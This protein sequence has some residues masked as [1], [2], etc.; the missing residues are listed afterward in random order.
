MTTRNFFRWAL[1]VILISL[2]TAS[3]AAEPAS[4]GKAA[5]KSDAKSA[6]KSPEQ[7]FKELDKNGDGK[8]KADEISADQ[9]A[10]FDHLVRNADKDKNGE[11]TLAEFLEGLK[12]EERRPAD[13]GGPPRGDAP[14]MPEPGRLFQQFDR[15]NDG[16][17]SLDEMPGPARERFKPAFDRLGKTELNRE[18][19]RRI[20]AQVRP[21]GVPMP[22]GG[23]NSAFFRKLD[24]NGDGKISKDELQNAAKIF[25]ELDVDKSGYLEPRELFGPP[26]GGPDGRPGDRPNQPKDGKTA[27]N[28][29]PSRDAAGTLDSNTAGNKPVVQPVAAPAKGD[30][31]SKGPIRRFDKNGDG[32]V[33]RDELPRGKL[34]KN[35]DRFDGDHDG[36]LERNELRKSM[37]AR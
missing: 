32:K 37:A 13:A 4:D 3:R 19:F 27:A 15:N 2:P 18:E 36:Y 26:P 31:A 11:L 24:T 1:I 23:P 29:S 16:K 9:R 20:A 25:D 7:L 6:E 14:P 8:L 28:G 35:F 34:R 17:V 22:G 33:S 5:G 21:G 12:P 10:L 30:K